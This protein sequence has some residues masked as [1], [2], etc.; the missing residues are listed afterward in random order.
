MS[1]R[2]EKVAA[3]VRVDPSQLRWRTSSYSAS[4]GSCVEVAPLAD[5][6]AIRDTKDR[7][8]GMLNVNRQAWDSFRVTIKASRAHHE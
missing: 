6:T 1:R 7:D 5:G 4:N 8:G 2:G 3:M